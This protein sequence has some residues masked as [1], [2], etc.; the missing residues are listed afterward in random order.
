MNC[1]RVRNGMKDGGRC[2]ALWGFLAGVAQAQTGV[3]KTLAPHEGLLT[4]G[5]VGLLLIFVGLGAWEYF[6]Q[7]RESR[8]SLDIAKLAAAA[9][10]KK[11]SGGAPPSGS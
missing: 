1:S 5:A 8:S 9:A 11:S 2:L 10:K 3:A 4:G 6:D 7:K